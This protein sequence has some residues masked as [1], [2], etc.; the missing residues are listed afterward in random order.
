MDVGFLSNRCEFAE[1]K[2]YN[3]NGELTFAVVGC[4]VW[5]GAIVIRLS[6]SN[7]PWTLTEKL[8][9][10][11]SFIIFAGVPIFFLA[12]NAGTKFAQRVL[13]RNHGFWFQVFT[14]LLLGLY[15]SVGRLLNVNPERFAWLHQLDRLIVN[16]AFWLNTALF[17]VGAFIVLRLPF[18]LLALR[19]RKLYG[20]QKQTIFSIAQQNSQLILLLVIN[21]IYISLV[22]TSL[23]STAFQ[24]EY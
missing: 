21:F 24:R 11:V 5:F 17:L 20:K 12:T 7:R 19:D 2:R 15:I 9:E 14:C 23:I 3:G 16:N 4:I 6:F 1:P 13:L 10:A 8:V 22:N 18:L